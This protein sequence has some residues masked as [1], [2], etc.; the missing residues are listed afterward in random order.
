MVRFSKFIYSIIFG[1]VT[2]GLGRVD[3]FVLGVF[4]DLI[5]SGMVLDLVNFTILSALVVLFVVLCLMT[6]FPALITIELLCEAFRIGN[7]ED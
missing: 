4:I 7:D 3:L 1:L 6:L 2:Y 5:K